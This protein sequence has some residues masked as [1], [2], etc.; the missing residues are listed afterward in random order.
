M[1]RVGIFVDADNLLPYWLNDVRTVPEPRA[2]YIQSADFETVL[3]QVD[4]L[5]DGEGSVVFREAYG[6]WANA[7]RS[8]PASLMYHQFGYDL[9]HVPPLSREKQ[10]AATPTVNIPGGEGL[11]NAGDILLSV[12]AILAASRRQ[13]LDTVIVGAADKDYHQLVTELKRLGKR[14]VCLAFQQKTQQGRLLLETFDHVLTLDSIALW[15]ELDEAQSASGTTKVRTPAAAKASAGDARR[16][17]LATQKRPAEPPVAPKIRDPFVL[18]RTWWEM[19]DANAST[20]HHL[21]TSAV[22][23]H[24]VTHSEAAAL[25]EG[26]KRG[27]HLGSAAVGVGRPDGVELD[28]W[29]HDVVRVLV[30]V[31]IDESIR[32]LDDPNRATAERIELIRG[33]TQRRFQSLTTGLRIVIEDALGRRTVEL[34]GT[35]PE[36]PN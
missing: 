16:S 15:D 34:T 36:E 31:V 24:N 2:Y 30:D 28:E 27:Q 33:G 26:L 4:A 32:I 11:K 8:I 6:H 22:L 29:K 5:A 17:T 9:Q 3:A 35:P 19:I 20:E 23:D 14:V 25:V 10:V 18:A 21:V 7:A 1:T 12:R 13:S